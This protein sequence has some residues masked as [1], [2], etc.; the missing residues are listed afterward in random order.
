MNAKRGH[1][2]AL[3]F[4]CGD[5]KAGFAA[6]AGNIPHLRHFAALLAL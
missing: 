5:D 6:I 3:V 1:E 4:F 2:F